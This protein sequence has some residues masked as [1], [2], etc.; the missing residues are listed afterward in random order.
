MPI[1]VILAII[2]VALPGCAFL[3]SRG[4]ARRRNRAAVARL[5]TEVEYRARLDLVPSLQE[6]LKGYAFDRRG[7]LKTVTGERALTR[8]AGIIDGTAWIARPETELSQ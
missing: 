5:G 1:W 7:A 3:A 4:G 8:R 6:A 2:T